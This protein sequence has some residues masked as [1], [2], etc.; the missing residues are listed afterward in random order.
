ML[1]IIKNWLLLRQHHIVTLIF[2]LGI[3]NACSTNTDPS[4]QLNTSGVYS[5]KD[6]SNLQINELTSNNNYIYAG[7]DSG[8]YRHSRQSDVANWQPLGL[9]GNNILDF[10]VW[11]NQKLL[12]GTNIDSSKDTS[13]YFTN[14]A[15]K[16][17]QP[18]QN[19]F[20]TDERNNHLFVIEK[21]PD[22]SQ[23]LYARGDFNVALS[24]DSGKSWK[25]IYGSWDGFGGGY[26]LTISQS[27]PKIIWG[28]GVDANFQ[29]HLFKSSD[30][31]SSWKAIRIIEN[32]ETTIYDLI[33]HP[34]KTTNILAGTA[35]SFAPAN[36]IRKST[37]GGDTWETVFEGINTRTF[38]HSANNPEWVYASGR[39]AD[40]SL[41]FVASGDF[42]ESWKTITWEE[43]PAGV[44]VS[45]MVS[46]ME[47]GREVLYFGTN[48]GVFSYR[49]EE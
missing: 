8:L 22:N 7:T 29:P 20:G 44:Q 28:G 36:L 37:N 13:I 35:G 40:G 4:K 3:I 11:K 30:G 16:N 2:L 48:Q 12:V 47:D 49:F 32:V 6:L 14:D 42:G 43:S 18:Y 41:F 24:S 21:H 17:W 19:G 27:N 10:V 26:F 15:G 5:S 45:D 23:K 31:G 34:Q 9:P 39:N 33:I 38:S 46:V 25:N 1:Q